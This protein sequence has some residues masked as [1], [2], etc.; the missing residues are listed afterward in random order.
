M[1]MR[2]NNWVKTSSLRCQ[3]QHGRNCSD[4]ICSVFSIPSDSWRR[5]YLNKSYSDF[6][7]AKD[8]WHQMLFLTQRPSLVSVHNSL[9]K[10]LS[11][12]G[13][14]KNRGFFIQNSLSETKL[15]TLPLIWKSPL[16]NIFLSKH[17]PFP[18]HIQKKEECY[19]VS[20]ASLIK[21]LRLSKVRV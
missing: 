21:P 20:K 16:R 17:L 11:D 8:V 3:G 2:I 15:S 7:S 4:Y 5:L 9:C 6:Q 19:P 10:A 1:R 18:C 12:N 13:M 14:G